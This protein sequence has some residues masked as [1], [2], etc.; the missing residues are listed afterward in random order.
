LSEWP[1]ADRSEFARLLMMF[2]A[3]IEEDVEARH[4][5]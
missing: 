2:A 3:T 5:H 1:K 4:G